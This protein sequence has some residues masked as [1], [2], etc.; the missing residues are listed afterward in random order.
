MVG[1]IFRIH[2]HVREDFSNGFA[3]GYFWIQCAVGILKDEL[4]DAPHRV[5]GLGL[6]MLDRNPI[7][8]D[9]ARSHCCEPQ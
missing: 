1:C 3:H 2:S 8:L 5:H 7:Q 6:A 9:G 4:G